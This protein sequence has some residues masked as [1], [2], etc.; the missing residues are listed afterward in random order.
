MHDAL[1]FPNKYPEYLKS[2]MFIVSTP[3]ISEVSKEISDP[4]T[5]III[6]NNSMFVGHLLKA[7]FSQKKQLWEDFEKRK[8]LVKKYSLENTL[9]SFVNKIESIK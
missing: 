8:E 2:N 9:I 3:Y 7:K 5:G 4:G 1:D 6:K